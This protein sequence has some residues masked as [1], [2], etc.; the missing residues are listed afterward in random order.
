MRRA[1]SLALLTQQADCDPAET[2]VG[3]QALTLAHHGLWEELPP[4]MAQASKSRK[5]PFPLI[6]GV[7]ARRQEDDAAYA[8]LRQSG[9]GSPE[10]YDQRVDNILFVAEGMSAR[11]RAGDP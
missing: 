2:L 4:L 10:E 3:L 1:T 6:R 7:E 5:A 8:E 9:G 11:R